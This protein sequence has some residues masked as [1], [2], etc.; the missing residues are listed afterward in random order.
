MANRSTLDD[1]LDALYLERGL[2][3][4]T[5]SAYRTDLVG[6]ERFAHE[7]KRAL[8]ELNEADLNQY[9]G[10][11][12][13]SGISTTSIQRKLS[14][15][16]G[17]YK[18]LV[19]TRQRADDPMARITRPSKGRPLPKTLS[20]AEVNALLD[21]P[22]TETRIGLRD[23]TLL[24]VLYATGLRVSELVELKRQNLGLEQGVIRVMGKGQK[25]RL[26]P[27]GESAREWLAR[28]LLEARPELPDPRGVSVFPGR[29]GEPMTRQ[30]FWHRIK[31]WA[32]V[33]GI[34]RAISPHTLRHAF[35]THLVNHGADLRVVQLLLGHTDL[36]TTQIYTH[37]ARERLKQLHSA[38]HPRAS[39]TL[40][41]H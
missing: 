18:Y 28:Y 31:H 12:F 25:E 26:V 29:S 40:T 2:S 33:A 19:R 8:P 4:K 23:R 36:S 5:L 34:D 30:T 39:G 1:Y 38:H 14:A 10:S 16:H 11:L 7:L 27:L 9:I 37:V 20:E 41:S 32:R 15:L 21:A 3:E 24:E 13:S 17:Y 35:A 22:D 6:A